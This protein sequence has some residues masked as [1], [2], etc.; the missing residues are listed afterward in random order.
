MPDA[1]GTEARAQP[2]QIE[3]TPGLVSALVDLQDAPSPD[4]LVQF[5]ASVIAESDRAVPILCF[6][7]IET[8]MSVLLKAAMPNRENLDDLFDGAAPLAAAGSQILLA[9]ALGWI[10]QDTKSDLTTLRKI[11]NYFAHNF[12]E[13]DSTTP[14]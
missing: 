2:P 13:M 7:Y 6:A 10:D 3:V 14:K 11:R 12:V 5:F 9:F 8:E 4:G 1:Y